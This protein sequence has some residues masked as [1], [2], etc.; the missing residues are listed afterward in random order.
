MAEVRRVRIRQTP[1]PLE[2]PFYYRF[3]A[4]DVS[5]PNSPFHRLSDRIQLRIIRLYLSNNEPDELVVRIQKTLLNG[6]YP[7]A[8]IRV[9]EVVENKKRRESILEAASKS[10]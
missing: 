3:T 10:Y 9:L 8:E 5:D 7:S 4:I 6:R 2:G 1:I